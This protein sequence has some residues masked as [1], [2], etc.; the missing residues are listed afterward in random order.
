M[1]ISK[2]T[3]FVDFVFEHKHAACTQLSFKN[4]SGI[5]EFVLNL[6]NLLILLVW[7]FKNA[8]GINDLGIH[9]LF[10]L[11]AAFPNSMDILSF[12]LLHSKAS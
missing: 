3:E 11:M 6:L 8:S 4:A 5:N 12:L 7:F 1:K 10:K 2:K 9:A